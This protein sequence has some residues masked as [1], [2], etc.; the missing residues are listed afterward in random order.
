MFHN[1][2]SLDP[3][4]TAATGAVGAPTATAD[5]QAQIGGFQTD[6]KPLIGLFLL[7]VLMFSL[8]FLKD[9]ATFSSEHNRFKEL[10]VTIWNALIG[11]VIV[12]PGIVFWKAM[13]VRFLHQ[14]NPVRALVNAV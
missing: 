6:S 4:P 10:D 11:A 8:R 9:A 13:T 12:I 7:V 2:I 1:L 5:S 3:P 14:D